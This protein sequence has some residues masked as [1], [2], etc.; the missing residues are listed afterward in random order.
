MAAEIARDLGIRVYTIGVGRRGQAPMP[1]MD[2]F[3]N[4][5]MVMAKVEIDEDLLREISKLTGGRYFRAENI[6]ALAKIYEEIDQMEKSKIE[7]TDYISYEELFINWLLWG[8]A[9]LIAELIVS[10]VVLRRLP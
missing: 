9:L 10:R 3:G 4:V 6:D 8:I 7:V 5:V 2:P 1:A